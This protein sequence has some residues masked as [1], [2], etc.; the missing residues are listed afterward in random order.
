MFSIKLDTL[1]S[2][3]PW[4]LQGTVLVGFLYKSNKMKVDKNRQSI[5]ERVLVADVIGGEV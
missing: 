4:L 5:F 1:N 2:T 3:D